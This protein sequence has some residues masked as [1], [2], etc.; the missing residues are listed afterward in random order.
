[1]DVIT[2]SVFKTLFEF[3]ILNVFAISKS[4]EN[5]NLFKTSIWFPFEGDSCATTLLNIRVIDECEA[6]E[7]FDEIT[8]DAHTTIQQKQYHSHSQSRLPET[9]HGCPLRV[10]CT[11]SWAPYVMG[12]NT[13]IEQGFETFMLQTFSERLDLNLSFNVI[14]QNYVFS[15]FTPDDPTGFYTDLIK[16]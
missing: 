9:F 4:L 14:D 2:T 8:N 16:R 3:S 1:M 12:D 13:S 7:F 5:E 6:I 11:A 15:R 10:S